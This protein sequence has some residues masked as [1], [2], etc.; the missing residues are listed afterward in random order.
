MNEARAP[1]ANVHRSHY[2]LLSAC[3]LLSVLCYKG[4]GR[5][6]FNVCVTSQYVCIILHVAS[7][8]THMYVNYIIISYVMCCKQILH[9][10]VQLLGTYIAKVRAIKVPILQFKGNIPF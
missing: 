1:C 9:K 7:L 10:V 3:V 8:Y 5:A 4:R 6:I 2:Q